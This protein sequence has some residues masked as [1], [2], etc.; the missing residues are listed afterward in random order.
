MDDSL[1]YIQMEM[2]PKFPKIMKKRKKS[3]FFID[4][5][6]PIFKYESWVLEKWRMSNICCCWMLIEWRCIRNINK[7]SAIQ[8]FFFVY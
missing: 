7:G 1:N 6:Y 8:R 2:E 5:T 4:K 3:A